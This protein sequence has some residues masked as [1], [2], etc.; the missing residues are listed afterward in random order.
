M[1]AV[2]LEDL[3][4][5]LARTLEADVFTCALRGELHHGRRA[6]LAA[7]VDELPL[8]FHLQRAARR[9]S[10]GLHEPARE[11]LHALEVSERLIRLDSGELRVVIR[12]H[13][14][15][16][17]LTPNFKHAFEATNEQALKR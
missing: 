1:S 5:F 13:A 4:E 10:R 3:D 9:H 2:A 6:P 12:I 7:Q 17:E 8:V 14:L 15:V 16:T 11:A